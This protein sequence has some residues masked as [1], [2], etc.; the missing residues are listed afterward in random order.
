M[1]TPQLP[2][3]H[4]AERRYEV[5][6]KIKA[7]VLTREGAVV[8]AIALV[9]LIALVIGMFYVVT[10]DAEPSREELL[11]ARLEQEQRLREGSYMLPQEEA[12]QRLIDQKKRFENESYELPTEDTFQR[13]QEQLKR[14]GL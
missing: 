13:E 1:D 9:A 3:W 6:Q 8:T 14:F 5:L 11:K 12:E 10:R 2:K 7:Y 4:S